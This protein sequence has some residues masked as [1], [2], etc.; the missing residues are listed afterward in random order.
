MGRLRVEFIGNDPKE[1]SFRIRPVSKASIIPSPL[2]LVIGK[3]FDIEKALELGP[4]W[5]CPITLKG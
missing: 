4:D 1:L 3:G 2:N 5:L